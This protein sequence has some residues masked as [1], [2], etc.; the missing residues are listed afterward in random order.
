MPLGKT[1]GVS[2]PARMGIPVYGGS[3]HG[4]KYRLFIQNTPEKK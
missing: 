1:A 2:A 3:R 4:H